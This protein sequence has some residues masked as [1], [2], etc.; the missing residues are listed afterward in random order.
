MLE[1]F[2]LESSTYSSTEEI[3]KLYI[4]L[5]SSW[6]QLYEFKTQL[7]KVRFFFPQKRSSTIKQSNIGV[8]I[9]RLYIKNYFKEN[10]N[11]YIKK[12]SKI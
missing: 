11:N 1:N 12:I 3:I 8:N 7:L 10:R 9:F 4:V 5:P 2:N 6:S